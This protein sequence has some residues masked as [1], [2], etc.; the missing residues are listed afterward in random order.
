VRQS[1][2]RKSFPELLVPHFAR[3]IAIPDDTLQVC[4][5]AASPQARKPASLQRPPPFPLASL[6]A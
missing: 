5:A 2:W 6:S 4:R 3:I 1:K